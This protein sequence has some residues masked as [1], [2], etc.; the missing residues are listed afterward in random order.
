MANC[1]KQNKNMQYSLVDL[2]L[3]GNPLGPDPQ[4]AL[5]FIQQPN[6][7][8]VLNLSKCG[9]NFEFVSVHQ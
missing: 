4:A 5:T 3:S 6:T 1:M 7:I 9:I 8:A 2:D